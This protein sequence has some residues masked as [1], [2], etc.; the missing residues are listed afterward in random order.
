MRE[1][2]EGNGSERLTGGQ[3]ERRQSQE[4]RNIFKKFDGKEGGGVEND[5]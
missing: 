3:K 5:V 1:E 2:E 4:Y